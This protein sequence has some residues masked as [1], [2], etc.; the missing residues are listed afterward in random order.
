MEH[1]RTGPGGVLTAPPVPHHRVRHN[2]RQW[3]LLMFPFYR[4]GNRFEEAK[5]PMII[6]QEAEPTLQ[7]VPQATNREGIEPRFDGLVSGDVCA[8]E[9]SGKATEV[10]TG[11]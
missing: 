11:R 9:D 5:S 6:S 8:S 2:P 3:V 1:V 7:S 10:R 4:K